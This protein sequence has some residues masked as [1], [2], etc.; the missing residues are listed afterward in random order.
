[1][2]QAA[3]VKT[4]RA[5]FDA[6]T[7]HDLSIWERALGPDF[8]ADYPCAPG[9][10]RIQARAYNTPF[11]EAFPDLKMVPERVIVQGNTVVLDGFA[12]GTF[13]KPLA[14]PQGMVPPNGR[15][16][17]VRI[18]L[19]VE[20][21]DGKIVREQTVWNQLDLFTQLGLIPNSNAA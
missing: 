4:A 16:G 12:S 14:T 20:I 21:R 5:L 3:L 11:V 19:I 10:D 15:A 7:K 13:S 2:D 8:V 17:G 9:L 18:V 6:F 1:M